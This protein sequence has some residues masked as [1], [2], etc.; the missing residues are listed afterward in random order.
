MCEDCEYVIKTYDM[1]RMLRDAGMK[2]EI[3]VDNKQIYIGVIL[4]EVKVKYTA[5]SWREAAGYIAG[6]KNGTALI[7]NER[8]KE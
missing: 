3:I 4:G 5:F 8:S 2:C 6:F 1:A 7:N